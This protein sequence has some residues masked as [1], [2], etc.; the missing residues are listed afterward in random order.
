VRAPRRDLLVVLL[1]T[2]SGLV[3]AFGF[4]G[5]GGS[6]TSV[7]TGNMVLLGVYGA[8]GEFNAALQVSV[9]IAGY[10]IGTALGS[11]VAGEPRKG[12]VVW[13]SQITRALSWEAASLSV[14]TI[15]W[16]VSGGRPGPELQAILLCFNAVGLGV[17]SA[18]IQ[19][20][21]VAGLSTTYLTGT[22]TTLVTS[23]VHRA[24]L[25]TVR[26]SILL[27]LA[28]IA[29]AIAARVLLSQA[30]LFCPVFLV[31][32]LLVVIGVARAT[33][34]HEVPHPPSEQESVTGEAAG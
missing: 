27:L 31:A 21:G 9:A 24:P 2:V 13:P 29:G 15:G 3:D 20:F 32:P 5:L 30:R 25:R 16:I 1:A 19:R 28:L 23:L 14:S 26:R 4:V 34:R 6:F 22:L 11:R 7:M 33:T 12:D 10:V 8:G 18:A 17:Q